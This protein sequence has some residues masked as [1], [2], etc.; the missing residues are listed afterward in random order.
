MR[1][2]SYLTEIGKF[3]SRTKA[4]QAV[5]RGEIYIDGTIKNKPSYDIPAD[6]SGKIEYVFE[7]R[8]VSLCGYKL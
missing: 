4:K 8:F 5:E 6:F 2:D 1:L 3:D 7:S